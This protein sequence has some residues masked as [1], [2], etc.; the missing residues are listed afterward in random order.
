MPYRVYGMSQSYFTRKMTGYLEYKGIPHLLRRFA[1]GLPEARAVGWSGGIPPVKTPEGEFMW[2]STPMILHLERRHPEPGVLPDDPV[3]RFLCFVLED[4]LDEWFYRPAVGSRWFYPENTQHGGWELARD[5]TAETPIT[6]QQAFELVRPFVTAS[7][8]P[9]GVTAENIDS[10][11]AEVL[12][13]WLRVLNDHFAARPYLFGE[14][15]SLADFALFG[16]NAAHFS[17]DPVCR[18]WSDECG[19]EVV[20]HT[21]RLLEPEEQ[22]FGDWTGVGDVPETLTAVLADLGRLYLPWV[23]RATRDGSAELA[24][25]SGQRIEIAATPFLQESRGVL[26]ARYVAARSNALD[27]ALDRAGILSYF[28]DFTDLAGE[29]P[30]CAKPPRPADNRPFAPP[31]EVEAGARLSQT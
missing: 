19:P 7:C 3:Q 26:L 11:I 5:F 28:A 16:A 18:R 14:R 27:A 8:E 9:M 23:S 6:A 17:N 24:F 20:R 22:K 12:K 10:W 30:D 21:H 4:V 2:D 13:P 29:I 15:P 25:A 1:G 31:P